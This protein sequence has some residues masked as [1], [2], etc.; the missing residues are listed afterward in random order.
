MR[1]NGRRFPLAIDAD[2]ERIHVI[3]ST[4]GPTIASDVALAGEAA[5]GA[6]A[7]RLACAALAPLMNVTAEALEVRR[8]GRIPRLAAAGRRLRVDLSLSHHGRFV[9]FAASLPRVEAA[10][11]P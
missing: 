3:A 8:D 1:W 9:A 11:V 4:G 6:A 10:F 7:R 5:P 2:D